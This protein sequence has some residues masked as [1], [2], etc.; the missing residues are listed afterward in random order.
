MCTHHL[1]IIRDLENSVCH[2]QM[3][4]RASTLHNCSCFA[5]LILLLAIF[6]HSEYLT[7]AKRAELRE[8]VGE[9]QEEE[10]EGEAVAGPSGKATLHSSG[11]T[12]PVVYFFRILC[13]NVF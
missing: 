6:P 7:S 2:L 10:P 13:L 4:N 9:V 12:P 5:A 3:K 1:V 8:L 11:S